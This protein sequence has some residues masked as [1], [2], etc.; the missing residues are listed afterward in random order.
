M[1]VCFQADADFNQNIVRAVRRRAPAID[2]QTAHEAG[3]HGLDDQ[4]V[5][6][7]VAREGRLLVSHDRRT[8]PSHFANFTATRTSAGVIL[9]SQNLSIMQAVEDLILIWEASE[10]EE[11]VNRLDSLPL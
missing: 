5:L 4:A 10:A 7:H 2:F 1:K 11:W 9:I 6:A 3:L 8:M